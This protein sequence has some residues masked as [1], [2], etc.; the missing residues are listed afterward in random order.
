MIWQGVV[1]QMLLDRDDV[2]RIDDLDMKIVMMMMMMI[3]VFVVAVVL[4]T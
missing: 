1:S 4:M 2:H 3:V